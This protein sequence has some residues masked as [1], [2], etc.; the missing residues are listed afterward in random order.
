MGAVGK[1]DVLN[2]SPS[3]RNRVV[4]VRDDAERRAGRRH[5][6]DRLAQDGGKDGAGLVAPK[7]MRAPSRRVVAVCA[8]HSRVLRGWN[9]AGQDVVVWSPGRH[10]TVSSKSPLAHLTTD[11]KAGRGCSGAA[12][13]FGTPA[14]IQQQ[15]RIT[16]RGFK[17]SHALNTKMLPILA[18]MRTST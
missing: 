4:G 6:G 7:A 11:G 13:L 18:P 3:W 1:E 16:A 14:G 5:D 10:A 9:G 15:T 2:M 12:R 8:Q 17:N